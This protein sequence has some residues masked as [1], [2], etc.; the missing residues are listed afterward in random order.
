MHTHLMNE[1]LYNSIKYSNLKSFHLTKFG[2]LQWKQEVVLN[3][4]PLD[5]NQDFQVQN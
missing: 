2:S 5:Y 4:S 1:L 3:W